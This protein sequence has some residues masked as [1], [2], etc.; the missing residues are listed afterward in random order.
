[1]AVL[2]MMQ[3]SI[4]ILQNLS[5]LPWIMYLKKNSLNHCLLGIQ[6]LLLVEIIQICF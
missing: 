5:D 2:Y 6:T 4:A 3:F 1:M